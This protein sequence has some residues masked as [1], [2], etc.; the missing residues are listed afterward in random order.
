MLI[1][2]IVN[3]MQIPTDSYFATNITYECTK[4]NTLKERGGVY[5]GVQAGPAPPHIP[6]L[7]S[8]VAFFQWSQHIMSSN[9]FLFNQLG[10]EA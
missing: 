6:D 5:V 7:F 9:Y 1:A 10:K 3:H 4:K 8:R 2:S